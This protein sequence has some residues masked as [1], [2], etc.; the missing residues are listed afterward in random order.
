MRCSHCQ[1]ELPDGSNYCLSC[2]APQPA[3]AGQPSEAK[4]LVRPLAGRKFAGVCAGF[5]DYFDVDVTLVR[6]AWVILSIVP[7]AIFGGVVVYLLAWM[8]MPVAGAATTGARTSG[9]RLTR[10][11]TD[12][13]I[14]GVCGGLGEYFGVDST[15]VRLLWV[16]LSI[17]PGAIFG[18][19]IAYLIAWFVVPKSQTLP[20]A[21][22]V[23]PS[24]ARS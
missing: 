3:S 1:Q 10:S 17:V 13:K 7:G 22:P 12:R 21:T 14:A 16:V 23:M 5:A 11:T 6:L 20:T 8:V 2:G 24:A 18:G 15:P 19:I 9:R 4:R